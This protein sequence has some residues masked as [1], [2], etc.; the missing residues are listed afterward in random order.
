MAQLYS[1]QLLLAHGDLLA[2]E[3]GQRHVQRLPVVVTQGH[4]H[5]ATRLQPASLNGG[6][7]CPPHVRRRYGI[8]LGPVHLQQDEAYACE[9]L[10]LQAAEER[11]LAKAVPR[12]HQAQRA[13]RHL[14]GLQDE[15]RVGHV[16]GG[17]VDG[18]AR[19]VPLRAAD[20]ADGAVG[21]L[22][23]EVVERHPEDVRLAFLG[24]AQLAPQRRRP[25]RAA[26]G[27]VA[28]PLRLG[29]RVP[30]LQQPCYPRLRLHLGHV[31]QRVDVVRLQGHGADPLGGAGHEEAAIAR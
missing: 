28:L 3:A 16:T 21:E 27:P 6:T 2:T 23:E 12:L 9:R 25:A 1:V 8:G 24:H 7:R 11:P 10:V 13:L 19:L 4:E 29:V 17:D 18:L 15:R 31:D 14:G 30:D 26:V 22:V 5:V 20:A